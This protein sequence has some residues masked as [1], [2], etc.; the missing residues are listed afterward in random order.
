MWIPGTP[1]FAPGDDVVLCLERTVDGYRTVS[2]AFS[3]FRV[4]AAVAGDRPLTRF[5]GVTVV[6]GRGVAGVEAARGLAE[7]R[8]AAGTVT[9]VASRAV[10][11]EGQATAAVGAAASNRVEVQAVT[12]V[13]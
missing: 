4:G 3:A 6:G 7:F 8:R 2:M 13:V 10:L 1:R 5:G 9:G 11:S 12:G